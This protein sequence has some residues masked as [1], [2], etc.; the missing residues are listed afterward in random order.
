MAIDVDILDA[1]RE[2]LDRYGESAVEVAKEH[3]EMLLMSGDQQ[4]HDAATAFATT[5]LEAVASEGLDNLLVPAGAF[6][7]L[8]AAP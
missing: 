6:L 1:A 5:I 4:T 7:V 8:H 2:L 3:A